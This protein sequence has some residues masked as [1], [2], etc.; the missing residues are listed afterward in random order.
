MTD[1]ARLSGVQPS[2]VSNWRRR[3]A[4]F[5]DA[6]GSSGKE[7][8]A[9]DEIA[10]WLAGRKIAKDD[11]KAGDAPGDT[12]GDR[13]LRNL[14]VARG[15]AHDE[16]VDEPPVAQWGQRLLPWVMRLQ[17]S[18]DLRTSAEVML[19]L[20]YVRLREP[21]RWNRLINEPRTSTM[22]GLLAPLAVK[23]GPDDHRV[24]PFRHLVL[25]PEADGAL[26]KLVRAIGSIGFSR[27]DDIIRLGSYLLAELEHAA[28]RGGDHFTPAELA[29]CMVKLVDPGAH[30][31]VYDPFCKAGEL[32]SATAVHVAEPRALSL[33][34]QAS[35]EQSWTLTKLNMAL[36]GVNVDLGASPSLALD[37]D[38]NPTHRFD[39]V[40]AN[41]PFNQKL[42]G[43][44]GEPDERRWPYGAPPRDRAN[45]AWL[46]HVVGKLAPD[47]RAAE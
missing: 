11:L 25:M 27:P 7:L 36:R 38:L 23:V 1:V 10:R 41:P 3:Y 6:T 14:G 20:L 45:F 31:S 28:G 2:A 29:R 24:R 26:F 44:S 8:Y 15:I 22:R 39:V 42:L 19:G 32:L 33:A 12:Y 4:D 34:G 40:L 16:R 35:N 17:V 47:G 21:S 30:D 18:G 13:F 43:Q 37:R 46:Q 5:P 9:V